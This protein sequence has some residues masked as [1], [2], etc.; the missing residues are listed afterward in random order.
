MDRVD[1]ET[2]DVVIFDFL[3]ETRSRWNARLNWSEPSPKFSQ[4]S[5]VFYLTSYLSK[6]KD[7][8]PETLMLMSLFHLR[9]FSYSRGSISYVKEPSPL[10]TR[11]GFI[12]TCVAV[13]V[14]LV[15][16]DEWLVERF[17]DDFHRA[18]QDPRFFDV[19]EYLVEQQW[20]FYQLLFL[21]KHLRSDYDLPT[22]GYSGG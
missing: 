20:S 14:T 5:A 16:T 10:D 2:T 1:E 18:S 21:L 7:F 17:T 12:G 19:G 4:N 11:F 13:G 22:T 8:P 15:F 6:L 3:L 9:I